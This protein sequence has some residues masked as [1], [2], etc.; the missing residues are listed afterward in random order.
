[1]NILKSLRLI[2]GL[3]LAIAIVSVLAIIGPTTSRLNSLQELNNISIAQ[4]S[5]TEASSPVAA[6]TTGAGTNLQQAKVSETADQ[7]T[8]QAPSNTANTI[9]GTFNFIK[10]GGD[11]HG[12]KV[13]VSGSSSDPHTGTCKH[14][15]TLGNLKVVKTNTISSSRTCYFAVPR[16]SFLQAGNWYYRLTFISSDGLTK[17]TGGGFEI[18]ITPPTRTIQFVKGGGDQQGEKVIVSANLSEAQSGI[19]TFNFLLNGT[20]RVTKTSILS[21]DRTCYIAIPTSEFPKSATYSL[22]LSFLS[23]DS[24]VRATQFP[25]DVEVR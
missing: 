4:T 22:N 18:A 2:S 5:T 3:C 6:A 25:Y 17:G 23:N 21:S 8:A 20:T 9:A 24:L 10:G 11:Q 15:F 16:S 1:M 14:T 12:E 7:T 13:I 19:C